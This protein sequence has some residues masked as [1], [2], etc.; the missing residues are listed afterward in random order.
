[1]YL[2]KD[3]LNIFFSKSLNKHYHNIYHLNYNFYN[4]KIIEFDIKNAYKNKLS[5]YTINE[6]NNNIICSYYIK[7]KNIINL[8]SVVYNDNEK[9]WSHFSN[10]KTSNIL[11]KYCDTIKY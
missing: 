9:C 4:G 2:L 11:F 6:S 8:E 3:S 7:S 1:M 5:L 10:I